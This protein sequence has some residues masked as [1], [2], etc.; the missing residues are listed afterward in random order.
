VPL[1]QTSYA[2]LGLLD[3]R[4]WTAYELAQQ[5]SRS[6]A[7][8]WPVSETQLYAEPKRLEREGL[9]TIT[10]RRAG[11]QRTRQLLRI[12]AK[13]RKVL[14]AWLATEPAAPR[15]QMETLLR[16]LLATAGTKDELLAAL[17]TTAATTEAMYEAGK[18]VVRDYLAGDNP[19]PERTHVNVLWMAFVHDLL[20]LIGDWSAFAA[21]EVGRWDDVT[22][23]PDPSRSVALLEA[24]LEDRPMLAS[25]SV[26]LDQTNAP[27][28]R[29]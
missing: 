5:A 11:P 13:G 2:I 14:R 7:Y 6:L 19:F 24:M 10:T 26:A 18:D 9:V 15:L 12:S 8:V 28:R 29:P 17:A 23:D 20:Q 25:G 21:E 4:D 27:R 22:G 3:L 16:T 1:T